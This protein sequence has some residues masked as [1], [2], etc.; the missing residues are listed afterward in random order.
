M[1]AKRSKARIIRSIIE[2]QYWDWIF[3]AVK[4]TGPGHFPDSVMVEHKGTKYEAYLKDLTEI[5]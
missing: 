3:D 2:D 1:A 4:V 5:K